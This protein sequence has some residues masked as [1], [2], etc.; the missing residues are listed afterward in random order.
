MQHS[1]CPPNLVF[2][3]PRWGWPCFFGSG[4]AFLNMVVPSPAAAALRA[5]GWRLDGGP[6]A[7]DK[8]QH[9]LVRRCAHTGTDTVPAHVYKGDLERMIAG[10]RRKTCMGRQLDKDEHAREEPVELLPA[11]P[12]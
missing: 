6:E 1:S 3:Q 5:A 4:R 10:K 9:P 8:V 2:S 11:R 7:L 12:V